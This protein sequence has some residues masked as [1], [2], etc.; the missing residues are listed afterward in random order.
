VKRRDFIKFLAPLIFA[1]VTSNLKVEAYTISITGDF[2]SIK[3]EE[4]HII[5]EKGGNYNLADLPYSQDIVGV[6]TDTPEIAI[7]EKDNPNPKY[8]AIT[9][10]SLVKVSNV[11]GNINVGDYITV[12]ETPGIGMKAT[13]SGYV[14][15]KALESFESNNKNEQ[16]TIR[17]GLD[18]KD[19]I[20]TP[21]SPRNLLKV[22]TNGNNRPFIY[23]VE[24]LRYVLAGI[25]TVIS[26]TLGI[27]SFIKISVNSV[28]AISR[29]PSAKDDIKRE[30]RKSFKFTSIVIFV[31]L[32]I[33]YLILVV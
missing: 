19:V 5:S 25:L 27:Y 15:G 21:N 7:F 18:I 17:V 33:S 14:I 26:F 11:N 2:D 31:G 9:G 28:Q 10:N 32:V 30:T 16:S 12:S 1:I 22:M 6:I 24:A 13:E 3:V 23:P 29:N 8:I 20:I 4:G